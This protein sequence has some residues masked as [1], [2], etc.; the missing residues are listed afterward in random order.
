MRNFFMQHIGEALSRRD[1]PRSLGR[2]DKLCNFSYGHL[3]NWPAFL[4]AVSPSDIERLASDQTGWQIWGLPGGAKQYTDQMRRG[5]ALMLLGSERTCEFI[6]SID[7]VLPQPS[8]DLSKRI[9][10]EG[11]FPIIVLLKNSQFIDL[12]W[13]DFL[14]KV[15]YRANY[16]ITGHTSRIADSKLRAIGGASDLEQWVRQFSAQA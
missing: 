14:D 13:S 8:P 2:P 12:L 4:D 16:R 9:W 1:F 5:D 10:G 7:Y 6:A 11:R 15:G 3:S